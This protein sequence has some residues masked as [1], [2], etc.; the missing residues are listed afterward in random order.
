MS[1]SVKRRPVG[2]ERDARNVRQIPQGHQHRPA[3]EVE[4]L[5]AMTWEMEGRHDV[6]FRVRKLE[7]TGPVPK[8][9]QA[10]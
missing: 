1:T 10:A 4:G 6:S 2:I 3:G 7:A 8:S 5:T 9:V